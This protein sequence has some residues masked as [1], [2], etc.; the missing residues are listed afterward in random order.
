MSA[1][2]DMPTAQA[3]V[4]E[5]AATADSSVEA[6]VRGVGVAVHVEPFQWS[7]KAPLESPPTAHASRA[8]AAATPHRNCCLVMLVVMGD[9]VQCAPFQ[10][11][12]RGWVRRPETTRPTAQASL[13]D[14]AATPS[15]A[16][17][18]GMLA[19]AVPGAWWCG[20]IATTA[21]IAAIDAAAATGATDADHR[22]PAG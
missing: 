3:S 20:S 4:A 7:M 6:V 21:V 13:A 16:L 19:I 15:S 12:I 18:F 8:E 22:R 1:P 9:R 14:T 10:R 5:T 17:F 2:F 11:M